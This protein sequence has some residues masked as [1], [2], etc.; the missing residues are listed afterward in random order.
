MHNL[1]LLW[2]SLS[3]SGSMV[4]VM[5]FLLKPFLRRF[6]KTWQY[7]IWLLAI[8]RLLIPFSPNV[9]SVGDLFHQVETHFTAQY[10]PAENTP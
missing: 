10:T 6:S 9:S 8:L 2:L 7:Y 5:I 3:L 1:L 4:I